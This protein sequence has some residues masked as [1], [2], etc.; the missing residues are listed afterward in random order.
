MQWMDVAI[1]SH[2]LPESRDS[3]QALAVVQ[4]TPLASCLLCLFATRFLLEDHRETVS[5]VGST[6]WYIGDRL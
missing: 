1:P 4:E 5:I 6:V 3:L 2:L